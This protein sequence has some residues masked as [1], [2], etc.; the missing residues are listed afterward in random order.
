MSFSCRFTHSVIATLVWAG[1]VA[2]GCGVSIAQA[3]RQSVWDGIY[4]DAQALRGEIAYRKECGYCH[5][6]DLRGKG[7]TPVLIGGTFTE[8]W[9][10]ASLYD[11]TA[12]IQS[13][14]PEDRPAGLSAAVYVDI[15]AYLLKAN[16]YPA[17]ALELT[18]GIALKD[19]SFRKSK[20]T[21]P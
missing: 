7:V 15:V 14:M 20:P 4:T 21:P 9:N 5:G 1:V 10:D 13:T 2:I 16:D 19:I 3:A 18:N 17:G 12:V 8:Q 6:D 11:L